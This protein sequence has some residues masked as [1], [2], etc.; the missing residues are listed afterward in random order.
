MH[1]DSIEFVVPS[2]G[3]RRVKISQQL[4]WCQVLFDERL[5]CTVASFTTSDCA[6]P[7]TCPGFRICHRTILKSARETDRQ[8]QRQTETACLSGTLAL[9]ALYVIL[10]K[11]EA[12][13]ARCQYA[14]PTSV[15]FPLKV[16]SLFYL[17]LVCPVLCLAETLLH[18]AWSCTHVAWVFP[19]QVWYVVFCADVRRCLTVWLFD[20]TIVWVWLD[21]VVRI[22]QFGNMKYQVSREKWTFFLQHLTW[23]LLWSKRHF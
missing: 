5:D 17:K 19:L 18:Q 8:K 23:L 4:P 2:S 14:V 10:A 22:L 12:F 3:K 1:S 9:M 21:S 15:L 11:M 16:E 20:W 6:V 7:S 13:E